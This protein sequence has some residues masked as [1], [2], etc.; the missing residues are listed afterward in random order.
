MPAARRPIQV[1]VVRTWAEPSHRGDALRGQIDHPA[2]GRRR[3]FSNFG[4]L[5]DFIAAVN[6][7]P[8]PASPPDVDGPETV[9]R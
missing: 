1:F 7:V 2:T 3:Y 9:P 8:D 6:D 4:D 5:C